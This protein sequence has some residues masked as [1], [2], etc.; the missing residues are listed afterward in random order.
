[1]GPMCSTSAL[2]AAVFLPLCLFLPLA[3]ASPDAKRLFDDLL[4]NYNR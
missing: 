1:M 4:A 3:G 2:A